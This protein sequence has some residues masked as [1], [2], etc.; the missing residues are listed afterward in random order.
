V[1]NLTDYERNEAVA[2]FHAGVTR[3]GLIL[4]TLGVAAQVADDKLDSA[5]GTLIA[6]DYNYQN[7]RVVADDALEAVVNEH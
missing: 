1:A 4:E 7:L 3:L 6:L 5:Q 2:K